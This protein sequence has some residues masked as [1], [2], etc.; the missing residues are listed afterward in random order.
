LYKY[1]SQKNLNCLRFFG[2]CASRSVTR[3]FAEA[4]GGVAAE[5]GDGRV[6]AVTTSQVCAKGVASSEPDGARKL[7]TTSP[8][9]KRF[10]DPGHGRISNGSGSQGR[11][12]DLYRM[13]QLERIFRMAV[14]ILNNLRSVKSALFKPFMKQ[15][16]SPKHFII[17]VDGVLTD[18][19][20]HYSAEGKVM[21][22]FGPND[23]DALNIL[24]QFMSIEMVSGDKRGFSI[25][26]K[27]VADDMKFP[28]HAVSTFERA[29][30]FE[31]RY[32]LDEVIYMGDGIFDSAV[33]AKV[34]YA[35]A[36]ANGLELTKK[37]A[38][39]V[40]KSRGGDNAVA[41][42]CLHIMEKFFKPFDPL[43]MDINR[44]SVWKKSK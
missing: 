35:I 27:R 43:R 23:A 14:K 19:Q 24:K 6:R 36:P 31:K 11:R 29:E 42:A 8:Q 21:K 3:R 38:H 28:L 26:K 7:A 41:E 22:I 30:W 16:K 25:T 18:G 12:F 32:N 4:R 39:F 2:A 40:T 44:S 1:T 33:F 10:S 9:N 34:G 13:H 37:Y 17:D 15:N 20:F 5:R